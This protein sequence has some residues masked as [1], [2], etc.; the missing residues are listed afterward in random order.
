MWVILLIVAII[1]TCLCTMTFTKSFHDRWWY[2]PVGIIFGVTTNSLWLLSAKILPDKQQIYIFSLFW[3]CI[4]V[5]VYFLIPVI[6]FGIKF[7]KIGFFGL[8]LIII[9]TLLIKLRSE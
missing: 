3:D 4:M 2:F 8:L 6:A 1:Q 7:D 9:G 5:G